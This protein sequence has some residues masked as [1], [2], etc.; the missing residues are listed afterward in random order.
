MRRLPRGIRNDSG[1]MCNIGAKPPVAPG[2]S[3]TRETRGRWLPD[4]GR[5]Y[6]R[7]RHAHF[8]LIYEYK[9]GLTEFSSPRSISILYTYNK[10][11]IRIYIYR[12]RRY[13]RPRPPSIT[14]RRGTDRNVSAP[15]RGGEHFDG[16][17]I[18]I[19]AVKLLIIRGALCVTTGKLLFSYYANSTTL[20]RAIIIL[21]RQRA[22]E[23]VVVTYLYKT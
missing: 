21:L 20:R 17:R 3:A 19:R 10:Y 2:F 16:K 4:E 13:S 6:T 23:K 1:V 12:Y 5:D 18:L 22:G 14:T 7:K 11:I 15:P 9:L 8:R